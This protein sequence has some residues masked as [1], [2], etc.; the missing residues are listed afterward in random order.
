MRSLPTCCSF[1]PITHRPRR[2]GLVRS[3]VSVLFHSRAPQR[4]LFVYRLLI[5]LGVSFCKICFGPRYFIFYEERRCGTP[6]ESSQA[7]PTAASLTHV[8]KQQNE[9]V[10]PLSRLVLAQILMFSSTSSP[11]GRHPLLP[12]VEFPHFSS[13]V[14]LRW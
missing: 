2:R 7:P 9:R 8:L 6:G 12:L 5:P 4:R 3:S 14:P 1:C 11:S 10:F 13:F